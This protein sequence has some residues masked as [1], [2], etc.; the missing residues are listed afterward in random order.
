[1]L[2]FLFFIYSH[3]DSVQNFKIDIKLLII[4]KKH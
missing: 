1:M 3:F 2:H 4:F